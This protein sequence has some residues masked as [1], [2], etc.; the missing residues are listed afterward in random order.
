MKLLTP[1]WSNAKL[2]KTIKNGGAY[3]PFILHLSPAETARVGYNVCPASTVG[4]RT[5]CLT[6][7]GRGR[8]G[9]VITARQRRTILFMD[10]QGA[11]MD[12]LAYEIGDAARSMDDVEKV[13]VRLNGTSDIA[14]E[15]IPVGGKKNIFDLFPQVV[16]WDYTKRPE[17]IVNSQKDWPDNYHLTFSRSESN[18]RV[19]KGLL[20]K[21]A[22]VAVVFDRAL[23]KS[24][25]GRAVVDGTKDDY[26]FL[27]PHNSLVGLIGLGLA[28]RDTSGFVVRN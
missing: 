10:H 15:D 2:S 18:E 24:Y 11:F 5:S 21:G 19:A 17:R 28:K 7:S 20:K 8:F 16:F 14:W 1:G 25:W 26:R 27:D 22:S 9:N 13:A 4:C 6:T 12:M 3:V 23:P